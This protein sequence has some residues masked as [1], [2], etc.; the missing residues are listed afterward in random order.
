M[1]FRVQLLCISDLLCFTNYF[2]NIGHIVRLT[3][4][5]MCIIAYILCFN[6]LLHTLHSIPYCTYAVKLFEINNT[7]YCSVCFCS[8]ESFQALM[9]VFCVTTQELLLNVFCLFDINSM[10]SWY[11]C[12]Y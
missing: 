6:P 9:S 2:V 4:Y 10:C 7:I 11:F 1:I 12:Y 8:V 5:L 3:H